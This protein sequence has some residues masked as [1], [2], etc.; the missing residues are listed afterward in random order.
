MQCHP[1][2]FVRALIPLKY[3]PCVE[4][5]IEGRHGLI[6]QRL[7]GKKKNRSPVTMS[8]SSG[9]LDEFARLMSTFGTQVLADVATCYEQVRNSKRIAER[10]HLMDLPYVAP[11]WQSGCTVHHTRW[12]GVVTEA[13]YHCDIGALRCGR[14][15]VRPTGERSCKLVA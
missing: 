11:L 6:T 13:V 4:R 5:V 1:A 3:T 10:L 8:L 12:A 14:H 7:L 15:A 2:S 9:R